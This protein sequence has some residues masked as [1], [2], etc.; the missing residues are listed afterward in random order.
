MYNEKKPLRVHIEL[1]NKCN[2]M[3]PQCGRNRIVGDKI[4]YKNNDMQDINYVGGGQL[5]VKPNIQ[6]GEL[7]LEDYKKV[8]DDK[9]YDTFNLQKINYCGNRSDPIAS[10]DLHEIVE[11]SHSR[12]S[13]T[14]IVIATNGGLKTTEWWSKFGKLMSGIR[15]NVVFGLDGLEDTHIFTDKEQILKK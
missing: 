6:T 8:F 10:K 13:K 1:S 7:V 4:N 14:A 5:Q 11:Y 9:F 2:A 3:C 15:H 12:D